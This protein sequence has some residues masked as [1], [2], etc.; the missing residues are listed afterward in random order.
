MSRTQT[1]E[2][3]CALVGLNTGKP[4]AD[5]IAIEAS[6]FG[7]GDRDIE[8]I[9]LTLNEVDEDPEAAFAAV[10]GS[11]L[12]PWSAGHGFLPKMLARG[13][14]PRE[15]A[16][17]SPPGETPQWRLVYGAFKRFGIHA[18]E[19]V[20]GPDAAA[21]WQITKDT[22]LSLTEPGSNALRLPEI[23]RYTSAAWLQAFADLGIGV[24]TLTG[25]DDEFGQTYIDEGRQM[26]RRNRTILTC[27]DLLPRNPRD[28]YEAIDELG[29]LMRRR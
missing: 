15:I 10:D 26:G 5:R 6:R 19:S 13:V 29:I 27:H 12:I 18:K 20:T 9:G 11:F 7:F 25:E 21:N 24:A 23:A 4:T 14:Y 16:S 22:R 3:V 8:P 1:P 28:A 2:R 17:F